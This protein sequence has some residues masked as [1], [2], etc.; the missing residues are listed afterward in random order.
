MKT[1]KL[2]TTILVLATLVVVSTALVKVDA[3]VGL[4]NVLG[5]VGG[6]LNSLNGWEN[7]SSC[8]YE[9][10]NQLVYRLTNYC[11]YSGL[12]G[13]FAA[14]NLSDEYNQFSAPVKN[15]LTNEV[16]IIIYFANT[17]NFYVLFSTLVPQQGCFVQRSNRRKTN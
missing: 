5:K 10:H 8:R 12:N 14:K 17:N 11:L 4:P 16:M 13:T 7:R 1:T 15:A 2:M 6:I 3:K 9:V